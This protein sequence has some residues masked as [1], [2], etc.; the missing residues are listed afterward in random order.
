MTVKKIKASEQSLLITAAQKG[1]HIFFLKD[2]EM[3]NLSRKKGQKI[4]W[5]DNGS[6]NTSTDD[7]VFEASEF[8]QVKDA[9]RAVHCLTDSL[10]D[11]G[12]VCVFMKLGTCTSAVVG[13]EKIGFSEELPNRSAAIVHFPTKTDL[14]N[15]A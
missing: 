12:Y 13:F 8:M 7:S 4:Q 9:V 11:C 15:E 14:D 2:N 1:A 10:G 6:I 3:P 5:F